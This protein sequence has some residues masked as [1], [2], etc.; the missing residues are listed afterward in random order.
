MMSEEVVS[1]FASIDAICSASNDIKEEIASLTSILD[2]ELID[3][4][5]HP[6]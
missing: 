2:I 3:T 4:S 6:L 1:K 5:N